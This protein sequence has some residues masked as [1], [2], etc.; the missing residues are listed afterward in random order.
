M[1]DSPPSGQSASSGSHR[2]PALPPEPSP[3]DTRTPSLSSVTKPGRSP[4]AIH[5]VIDDLKRF[6]AGDLNLAALAAAVQTAIP[7]LETAAKEPDSQPSIERRID[8]IENA[9][10]A[11]HRDI[12]APKTYATAATAPTAALTPRAP[13]VAKTLPPRHEREI[14]VKATETEGRTYAEIVRKINT[15]AGREAAVAARKL[16]SGDYTITCKTADEKRI[17][18]T[19]L[20]WTTEAFREKASV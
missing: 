10:Q 4:K 16:P 20:T 11:I 6:L 5:S 9:L 8:A 15:T 3:P 13:Q 19:D 18:E 17:L 14:T 7:I 1:V 12:K 2:R